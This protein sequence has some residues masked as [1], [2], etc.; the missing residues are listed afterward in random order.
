MRGRLPLLALAAML[1]ACGAHSSRGS[2]DEDAGPSFV[3]TLG[4]FAGF[5]AWESFDG[6]TN[7]GD[8]LDGGIRTIYLN[9]P[10][11]LDS[12]IFPLGTI[13]VKTTQGAQ[14]FAMAK[15]GG[16]F[17]PLVDDWEW[18]EIA[19]NADGSIR[20]VWRGQGP[21]ST[22]VYGNTVATGCN[23]CHFDYLQNDFV[24]DTAVPSSAF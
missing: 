19:P 23:G 2:P 18:F 17:N 11:P 21:P 12:R 7:A 1:P 8:M 15:R 3:A 22:F 20:I 24:A 4:D 9:K 14:T 16:G 5:P 13:L 6:G 10:R